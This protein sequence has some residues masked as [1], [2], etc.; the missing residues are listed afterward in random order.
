MHTMA[1][2]RIDKTSSVAAILHREAKQTAGCYQS[3]ERCN[4]SQRAAQTMKRIATDRAGDHDNKLHPPTF[5]LFKLHVKFL[6]FA[7]F[8]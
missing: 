4:A 5:I 6:A 8:R 2:Q 3:L 7:L 1:R